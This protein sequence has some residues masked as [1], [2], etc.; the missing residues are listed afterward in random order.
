M[1]WYYKIQGIHA[2][3]R[4]FMNGA[5]CGELCFRTSELEYLQCKHAGKIQFIDETPKPKEEKAHDD[6]VRP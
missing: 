2:H 3:V 1:K 4:V 6:Q 5:N